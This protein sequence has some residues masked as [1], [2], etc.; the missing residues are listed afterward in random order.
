MPEN[1]H[2]DERWAGLID[3]AA[4]FPPGNV[5][6]SEAVVAYR[7][8]TG[9]AAGLVANFVLPDR[10]L[11][12]VTELEAPLSV[13]IT[14]GAGQIEGPL[15]QAKRSGLEIGALEIAVRDPGDPAGN[16]RRMIAALEQARDEELVPEDLP[17][18]IELP[19]TLAPY[20][21]QSAADEVAS[22]E[23]RLKFRTGGLEPDLFP[24]P[25]TLAEW[26]DGALD[27]ETPFKA[28]AGLHNAVRHQDPDG[29]WWHHGF[30]NL[31]LA[32][33]LAFDGA[34][35]DEVVATLEQTD[36]DALVAAITEQGDAMARIRRWFVSIGS[37]SVDEPLADLR[38][39]GLL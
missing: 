36:P 37:C 39:L 38:A 26:V 11:G 14:G 20:G 33:R 18:Y 2:P 16:V 8:R 15:R 7:D 13:V 23:L 12:A 25:A 9:E 4:I 32:T 21:W 34:G 31:M 29:R 5:P 10:D 6:L 3:D 28:T 22:A 19:A 27:R 1:P 30:L 35:R 24:T 17:T